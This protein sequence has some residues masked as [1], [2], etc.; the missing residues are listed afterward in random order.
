[1]ETW[2]YYGLVAAIFLGVSGFLIKV[3]GGKGALEPH[4]VGLLVALG[5]MAALG[6]YYLYES[7]GNFQ[8]PSNNLAM[9]AAIGSGITF[10]IGIG[11]VY[12]G[13]KLGANVAQMAPI[14]NMNTI[15]TVLLAIII[16]HELPNPEQAVKVV[17]GA[18]L[19]VIGAMLVS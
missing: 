10:G 15:V 9:L 13:I 11:I 7:R 1:M 3:A 12:N 2:I 4:I 19:M 5:V 14:Y 8:L 17:A 6:S 18:V 16:L